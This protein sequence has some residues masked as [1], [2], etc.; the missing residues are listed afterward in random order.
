LDPVSEPDGQRF[1]DNFRKLF[2][3]KVRDTVEEKFRMNI[4]RTRCAALFEER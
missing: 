2:G 3:M 4:F 1:I